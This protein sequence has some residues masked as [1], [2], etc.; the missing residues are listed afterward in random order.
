MPVH[1][2]HLEALSHRGDRAPALLLCPPLPAS[3]G[4]MDSPVLAELAFAAVRAGH[5]T[6]RF[7]YR[8][9]GASQGAPP[10]Y[11]GCLEDARLALE[12][13]RANTGGMAACVCGYERG[14]NLALDLARRGAPE[15][16]AAVA[17]GPL[18]ID[19]AA[20]QAVAV[21]ILFIAGR[22]DPMV[23]RLRLADHCAA[24]GDRLVVVA[25]ADHV[26]KRGLSEVG[27]A[28]AEFLAGIGP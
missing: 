11:D 27:R 12:H 7:N 25:G 23:D 19:I 6:L 9:V 26:F 3:G 17:V 16:V 20:L 18:E 10:A 4:S 8:G 28:T 24:S 13:L 14:A 21:P 15:I 22:D 5:P 1:D 2:G